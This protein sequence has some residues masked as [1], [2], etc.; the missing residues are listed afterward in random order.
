MK[1]EIKEI[2]YDEQLDFA[3]EEIAMGDFVKHEEVENLFQRRR[4][5]R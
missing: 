3:D 5:N 4:E 2:D 1:D